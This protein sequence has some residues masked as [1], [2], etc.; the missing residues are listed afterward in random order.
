M[1]TCINLA[2]GSDAEGCTERISGNGSDMFG[3]S[4]PEVIKLIQ[5]STMLFLEIILGSLDRVYKLACNNIII[6]V[7]KQLLLY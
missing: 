1:K 3:F 6:Y 5:V 2:N 7:T 4:N